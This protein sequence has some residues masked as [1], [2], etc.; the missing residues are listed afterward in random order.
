MK[1]SIKSFL[2]LLLPAFDEEAG[3][4]P[5]FELSAE[6]PSMR[7][8]SESESEK[9]LSSGAFKVFFDVSLSEAAIAAASWSS[10]SASKMIK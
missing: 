3:I 6:K 4:G 5:E 10:S 2:N 1:R 8:L 9:S 7:S